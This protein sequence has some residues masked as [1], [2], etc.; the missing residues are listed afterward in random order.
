M[1]IY[2]TAEKA[3]KGNYVVTYQELRGENYMVVFNVSYTADEWEQGIIPDS[4]T[5]PY[6]VRLY[7]RSAAEKLDL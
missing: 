6:V 2:A 3:Y 7:C 4:G 1:R 5:Y